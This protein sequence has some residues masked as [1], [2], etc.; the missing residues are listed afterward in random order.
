MSDDVL[1]ELTDEER[2]FL[3]EHH[4]EPRTFRDLRRRFLAGELGASSNVLTADVS[5]P[6]GEDVVELPE[7]E[8]DAHRRLE[9]LGRRAL[10]SGEVGV[11]ILNGGMATRFGGVVKGVVEA[12][13]GTSFLGLKFAD[14]RRFEGQ[15]PILVMNSF[16]THKKTR[17]HLEEN[18]W[19]GIRPEDVHLFEQGV[20][21]RLTSDGSLYRGASGGIDPHGPGHGDL[22]SA[23]SRGALDWFLARGGRYLL[24]SN[25]DNVLATLD[26]VVV[27]A[28]VDAADRGVEMTIEAVPRLEGD[29]GG[30]PARVDGRV[31]VVEHFR[32]PDGFDTSAI[33]VF[34]TN[35]F[36]FDAQALDRDF[37]LTWFMV[38]KMVDGDEVVQ[39][40]RLAGELSA[41]LK[42]QFLAVPR[43]GARSRFLA[44]KRPEDLDANRD[45]LRAT[46]RAR[47]IL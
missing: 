27:G 13:D 41:F 19:F 39:F 1:A 47:G 7:P 32:F 22:P 46:L 29:T 15:V 23:L 16:A 20:S 43:E 8:S 6:A 25:V 26:P 3:E 37:E 36:I 5:L 45:F 30:M 10:S 44:I 31:Q 14:A 42:S 34:N 9:R 40:E 11:L 28:H 18:D 24:M 17:E 33:D 12:V 4:F 38:T 35:T 21:L 2:R